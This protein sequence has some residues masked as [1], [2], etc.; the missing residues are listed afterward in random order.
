MVIF[1]SY[2][3]LPEGSSLSTQFL[4]LAV[5]G[6]TLFLGYPVS[7]LKRNLFQPRKG[8]EEMLNKSHQRC[9]KVNPETA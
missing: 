6:A 1:H 4:V 7:A 3:S 8:L 9:Q 5:W 2:V